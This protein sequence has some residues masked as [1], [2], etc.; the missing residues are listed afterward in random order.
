[1][2][3]V[4]LLVY[5]ADVL[6]SLDLIATLALVA[7]VGGVGL[8]VIFWRM[9]KDP[10]QNTLDQWAEKRTDHLKYSSLYDNPGPA[11]NGEPWTRPALWKTMKKPAYVA[12][13]SA[14]IVVITPSANTVYAIAASQSAEKVISS[15]TV[16]KAVDAL[17]RWLDRQAK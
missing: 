1:M 14:V 4:S 2:N 6:Q 17:N 8:S 12:I 15:P 3:F 16:T 13:A 11:P 10:N 9:E 5:L 7:S